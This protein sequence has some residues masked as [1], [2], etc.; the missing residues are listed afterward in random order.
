MK[1]ETHRFLPFL[2]YPPPHRPSLFYGGMLNYFLIS[3]I[4]SYLFKPS[5]VVTTKQ[6]AAPAEIII[7]NTGQSG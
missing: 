3:L 5:P 4:V 6:A 7:E 2:I 1:N